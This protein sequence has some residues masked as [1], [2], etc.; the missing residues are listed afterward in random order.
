MR[1]LVIDVGDLLRIDDEI[2]IHVIKLL[3]KLFPG[4]GSLP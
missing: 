4:L 2:G 1:T 3:K